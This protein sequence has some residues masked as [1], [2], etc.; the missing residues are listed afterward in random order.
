MNLEGAEEQVAFDDNSVL[1]NSAIETERKKTPGEM[2]SALLSLLLF[3]LF[4]FPVP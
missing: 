1:I 3:L 2:P 4:L